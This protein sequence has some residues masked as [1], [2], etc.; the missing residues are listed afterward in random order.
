MMDKRICDCG[1]KNK[2]YRNDIH[3][4]RAYCS[5]CGKNLGVVKKTDNFKEDNQ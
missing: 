1:C 4:R 3:C 5:A 2:N